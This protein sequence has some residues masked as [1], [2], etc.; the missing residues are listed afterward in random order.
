MKQLLLILLVGTLLG[1]CGGEDQAGEETMPDLDDPETRKQ[2]IAEAVDFDDLELRKAGVPL[3]IPCKACKKEVSKSGATCANCSHPIADSLS[4]YKGG[5]SKLYYAPGQKEAYEGWVKEKH[6]NGR[7]KSLSQYKG[8]K[9]HGSY[10]EWDT[11]GNKL[12][13]RIENE[14]D[15]SENNRRV[16]LMHLIEGR[17]INPFGMLGELA[18]FRGGA[19][20][21]PHLWFTNIQIHSPVEVAIA[22]EARNSPA[23][24]DFLQA[25]EKNKVARIMDCDANSTLEGAVFEIQMEWLYSDSQIPKKFKSDT[26]VRAFQGKSYSE[27]VFFRR[28]GE[29]LDRFPL[30]KFSKR[31]SVK[32]NSYSQHFIHVQGPKNSYE[33]ITEVTRMI[34]E[35]P[36]IFLSEATIRAIYPPKSKPWAEVFYELS[37]VLSAIELK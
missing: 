29:V 14:G 20:D 35:D 10:G 2:I 1:G 23:I 11:S 13:R 18:I 25:L 12:G 34:A 26:F 36:N 9:R 27:A 5:M 8:G 3:L 33:D 32:F 22:G 17:T 6:Y 30:I 31:Q 7:I 16:T 21:Q 19:G 4:E 37:Y 24:S 15:R 28:V